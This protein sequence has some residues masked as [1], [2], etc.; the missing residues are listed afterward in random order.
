MAL[1]DGYSPVG[2]TSKLSWITTP[3]EY[4]I[5]VDSGSTTSLTKNYVE[6]NLVRFKNPTGYYLSAQGSPNLAKFT[7]NL[8]EW[9]TWYVYKINM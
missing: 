6:A 5:T 8:T 1:S 9:T 7:S 3:I 2:E 4:N